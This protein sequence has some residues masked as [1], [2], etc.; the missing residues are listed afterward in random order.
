MPTPSPSQTGRGLQAGA[1]F[2]GNENLFES[3]LGRLHKGRNPYRT[4]LSVS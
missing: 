4:N 2:L 1:R 3:P